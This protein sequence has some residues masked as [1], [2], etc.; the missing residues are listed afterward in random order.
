MTFTT[1]MVSHTDVVSDQPC[2]ERHLS[3]VEGGEVV[4]RVDKPD[5][6]EVS[7][8]TRAENY[9]IAR[10]Y[11]NGKIHIRG[12]KYK[13]KLFGDSDGSL[14]II[15]LTRAD[16]GLYKANLRLR[17]KQQCVEF[18]LKVYDKI[19]ADELRI[20]HLTSIH[21]NCTVNLTCTI[22]RSDLMVT[23]SRSDMDIIVNSSFVA[24]QNPNAKIIYTCTAGNPG[25]NASKSITP[26]TYCS[27]E[28]THRKIREDYTL[29]NIGRLVLSG[30]ILILASCMLTCHLKTERR[31]K[32]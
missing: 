18:V 29:A 11:P 19:T 1:S 27:K 22:N 25:T 17:E 24:V 28:R 5:I 3:S 13:G 20:I 8:V 9:N 14:R 12:D 7:W 16:Q 32:C 26:W 23:W 21:D 6:M 10:T 4:L 31:S 2:V 15:N 30:C